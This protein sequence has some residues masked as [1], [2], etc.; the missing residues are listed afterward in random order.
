MT[1]TISL[2][3]GGDADIPCGSSPSAEGAAGGA[4]GNCYVVGDEE[5]AK[6]SMSSGGTVADD[7]RADESR[8][9]RQ[10]R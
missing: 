3:L 10:C 5:E 8:G 2:L 6:V 9:R 7:D 1:I 4:G